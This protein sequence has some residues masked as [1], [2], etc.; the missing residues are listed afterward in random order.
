MAEVGK[1]LPAISDQLSAYITSQRVAHLS[2][3]DKEGRPSIVPVCFA[4]HAGRFYIALDSKPKSVPPTHLKRVRNIEAN[5]NVALLFD[6]Y[7]EDWERLTYTLVHGTA[8]LEQPHTPEHAGG[9]GM[10]LEKYPQYRSMP[11]WE[12]PLIAITPTS[13]HTWRG[14]ATEAEGQPTRQELDFASL[15]RGRHV[16]RQFLSTEVPRAL[17]ELALEAARW[18]PSPHGM[19]PW[20]FVVITRPELRRQLADAMSVEWR[21]NLEMDGESPEMVETRLRKS[22]NRLLNTP[23]LIIPCLYMAGMHDYPDPARAEAEQIMAIQSLGAA[24]Q[25][26]LLSAYSLGLDTGWMCAPLF[27]PDLVRAVLRLDP[28]LIP[29]AI[30]Q[31]GYAAT[32]PPRRP[33]RPLSDL[34]VRYD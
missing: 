27:C 17:V 6:S 4:I 32:D 18:A 33:H 23:V 25:N 15:A 24:V 7:Y 16:V 12:Q 30:I 3:V 19:Q 22:R 28:A 31:L 11:I 9:T 1:G 26:M 21:R 2:T 20:R 29:H 34:I 10:L 13:E 14:G 8:T 5:P